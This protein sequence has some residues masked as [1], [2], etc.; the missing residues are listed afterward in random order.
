MEFRVSEDER[1]AY[2][3]AAGP[4]NMSRWIRDSCAQRLARDRKAGVVHPEVVRAP[5]PVP[6]RPDVR[7]AGKHHPRC[8]CAICRGAA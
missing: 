8:A 5:R 7:P 1:D 2:Q 4:R 3:A 6:V